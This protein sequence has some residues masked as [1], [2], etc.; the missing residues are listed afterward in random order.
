MLNYLL[1]GVRILEF[2]KFMFWNF[3]RVYS[4]SKKKTCNNHSQGI[5][6]AVAEGYHKHDSQHVSNSQ[7][8]PSYVP[9]I[10]ILNFVLIIIAAY[11]ISLGI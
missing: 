1:S 6:K 9:Q 2:I 4:L 11:F 3:I 7:F 10:K 8:T 5:S